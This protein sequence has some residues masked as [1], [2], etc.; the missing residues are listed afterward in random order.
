MTV[1]TDAVA[2]KVTDPHDPRSI[3]GRARARRWHELVRRVPDLAH[4]HVV[5]LGGTVQAWAGLE[6]HPRR[7]TVVNLDPETGTDADATLPWADVL[8]ADAAGGLEELRAERFDVVYSNSL[9]EHLGGPLAR[10]AFAANVERL[11]ERWWVQTPY[12]Y[13]PIEP[14][15]V[16]P[17]FQWLPLP[18]RAAVS[19]RWPY[20]HVRSEA[21]PPEAAVRDVTGVELLTMT[22][23]RSLFPAGHLYRERFC[24]L[25]KSIVAYRL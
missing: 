19:R 1:L 15:W 16:F 25:V 4:L 2:R 22:E 18:A 21:S 20:G 14:H 9:I 12:R 3:A 7:L 5:D 13:F 17:G 6:P 24:G 11:A 10:R 8:I 23:M